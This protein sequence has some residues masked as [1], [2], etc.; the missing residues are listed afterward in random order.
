MAKVSALVCH[1][2]QAHLPCVV[3]NVFWTQNVLKIVHVS[4]RNAWTLVLLLVARSP[5][6]WSGITVQSV[7]AENYT[8]E[9]HSPCVSLFHVRYFDTS[10]NFTITNWFNSE[11][12]KFRLSEALPPISVEVTQPCLPSPCGPNSECRVINNGPSCQCLST[13]IGSPPNC[14]PECIINSDCPSNRACIRQKCT[15]PCLGSCG[16]GTQCSVINHVPMCICLQEY[17]GDPFTN[18]YPMPPQ[19]KISFIQK[20]ISWW[21]LYLKNSYSAIPWIR[22]L[23]SITLWTKCSMQYRNMHMFTELSRWSVH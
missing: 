12:N 8:Q 15:D 5:P 3:Q 22:P 7:P 18:C 21:F 6:V 13:Y 19:C 1:N 23:Q 9:I 4:I 20:S 2:T 17:T 16:V 10:K 14:R 11:S